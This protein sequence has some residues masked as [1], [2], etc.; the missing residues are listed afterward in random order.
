MVDIKRSGNSKLKKRI[1]SAI[2]IV[3]GLGHRRDHRRIDQAKTG[4]ANTRP[5]DRCR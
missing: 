2:L 1:R 4:R 5:F 3:I